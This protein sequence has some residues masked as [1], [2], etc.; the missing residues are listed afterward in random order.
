MTRISVGPVVGRVTE[1]KARLLVEFDRTASVD[2]IVKSS[3]GDHQRFSVHVV[4]NTATVFEIA[5]L[6]VGRTYRVECLVENG[7]ARV[8]KVRPIGSKTLRI[9]TVSCYNLNHDLKTSAWDELAQ[10]ARQDALDVVL[11]TGDQVYGDDVFA[12]WSTY[13]KRV[14]GRL[15]E[16]F[17]PSIC[18]AYRG[19][20]RAA[21]NHPPVQT[22]L[23]N[24][25]NL[26]LWDDHEVTDDWGDKRSF[27]D[28]N[29]TEHMVA[30]CGWQVY[31]EYQRHLWDEH[32][33]DAPMP[34]G[35]HE[36]HVQ[37][38]GHTAALFV[39]VRG[40]RAFEMFDRSD[41]SPGVSDPYLGGA[42]WQEILGALSPASTTLQ[43]VEKLLVVCPVPLAFFPPS[44]SQD[45]VVRVIQDD[46]RGHWGHAPYQAEQHR[47]LSALRNW[48]GGAA[49]R[50]VLLLGG[51]VHF[52]CEIAVFHDRDGDTPVFRQ[53]VSSPV[54]RDTES[55]R[56]IE[57]FIVPQLKHPNADRTT[58]PRGFHWKAS[59]V[60]VRR[61]FAEIKTMR[62]E[63]I[64]A[65][66]VET[67]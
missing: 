24:A 1:S 27:A 6:V 20:Y 61:N 34:L 21:W 14:P 12:Y 10:R 38:W 44:L 13:L 39:D 64:Q 16:S 23:R 53:V 67:Q 45:L 42:Q 52:G 29:S 32:A 49:E 55:K 9:A 50:E 56:L 37:V 18:E 28:P 51:D 17:L 66:L 41:A 19:L 8:A 58:R 33:L 63:A 57:A 47:L 65:N 4:A 36:G 15:R 60:T 48:Q 2:V 26:M 54:H 59:K 5:R 46:I 40:G 11:H 22:V 35:Q 30:R 3:G 7:A 43:G 25:S 62:G 31:R